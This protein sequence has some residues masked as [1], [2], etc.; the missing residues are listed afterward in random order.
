VR[1]KEDEMTGAL[2]LGMTH[3]P[4]LLTTDNL[5][6][7][8]LAG[9]L[10]DP[11]IPATAKDPASWPDSMRADWAD[12]GG[13]AAAAVH[14]RDLLNGL[15]RV[16]AA[17]DEFEPDIVV[18]WGD[19]QYENFREEVVPPFCVLAYEDIEVHPFGMIA[20]RH[21]PNYWGAPDDARITLHGDAASARGHRRF[22]RRR[23]RHGVLVQEA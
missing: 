12:D 7:F 2:G 14:R 18:V 9:T 4:M 16:R 6:A 22:A 20:E 3:Y 8:L 5:M 13:T 23:F 1:S 21:M 15:A 19:D 10:T 11:D 17:L